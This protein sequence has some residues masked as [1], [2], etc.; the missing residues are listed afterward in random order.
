MDN[1]VTPLMMSADNPVREK[2]LLSS[3][4]VKLED[5]PSIPL[6]M[7]ELEFDTRERNKHPIKIDEL[8][9]F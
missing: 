7:S 2:E 3:N 5:R 4:K 8:Y 9:T 6:S 1:N